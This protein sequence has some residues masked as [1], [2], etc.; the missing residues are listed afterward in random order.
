MTDIHGLI[1]Y[2]ASSILVQLL[3]RNG[4]FQSNYN[5]HECKVLFNAHAKK[6]I[7]DS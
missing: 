7:I 2:L 6:V 1:N 4:Q 5:R 3:F